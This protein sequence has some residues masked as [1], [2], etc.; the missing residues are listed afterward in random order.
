MRTGDDMS[1]VATHHAKFGWWE[2][3][4]AVVPLAAR[5]VNGGGGGGWWIHFGS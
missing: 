4:S 2:G 1:P 3:M 5:G